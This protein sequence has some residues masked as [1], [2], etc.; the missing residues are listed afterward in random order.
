MQDRD[1]YW[2]KCHAADEHLNAGNPAAAIP[3]YSAIITEFTADPFL[4]WATARRAVAHY[5]N[6]NPTAAL[7][8]LDAVERTLPD[9]ERIFVSLPFFRAAVLIEHHRW[10]EAAILHQSIYDALLTKRTPKRRVY[11][12]HILYLLLQFEA[13]AAHAK[14]MASCGALLKER[15]YAIY[16]HW[17][18][19]LGYRTVEDWP[20][21]LRAYAAAAEQAPAL[22]DLQRWA[23]AARQLQHGPLYAG[24]RQK[25]LA[26]SE[27]MTID[28]DMDMQEATVTRFTLTGQQTDPTLSIPGGEMLVERYANDPEWLL[29]NH[30]SHK[31]GYHFGFWRPPV[32]Y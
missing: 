19:G 30:Q 10:D 13:K 4:R 17:A 22:T 21:A 8:D 16:T 32:G 26:G 12:Y 24:R 20:A 2:A 18:M 27:G 28:F 23:L 7:H 25:L 5:L 1:A 15:P 6:D 3:A 9:G 29:V 31:E 11:D 14:A